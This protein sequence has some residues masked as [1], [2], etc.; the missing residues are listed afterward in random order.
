MDLVRD[1][2]RGALAVHVL[3]HAAQGEVHGAWLSDELAR[4]GYRVSPGT[5]YPLLHRL[6]DAGLVLDRDELVDGR[7]LRRYRATRAGKQ[8]LAE[9]RLSIRELADE[10]A[11]VPR[12][13]SRG[14]NR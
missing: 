10:V 3:H 4:H 12:V 6:V 8:A 7:L 5:L 13:A 9:L 2:R 1:F 11:A 14:R